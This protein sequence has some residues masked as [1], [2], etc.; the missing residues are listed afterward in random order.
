MPLGDVLAFL[1]KAKLMITGLE[2]M[3]Q[4]EREK[5]FDALSKKFCF[6]CGKMFT[7]EGETCNCEDGK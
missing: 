3:T 6:D 7:T 4:S 1:A 5:L 2:K